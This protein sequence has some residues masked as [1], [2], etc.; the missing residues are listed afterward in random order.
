MNRQ[1]RVVATDVLTSDQLELEREIL[2]DI[3]EVEA[4][5][6]HCEDDLDS[7]IDDADAIIMFHEVNERGQ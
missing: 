5:D 3:A 2:G 7:R 4:L 6:A 1:F